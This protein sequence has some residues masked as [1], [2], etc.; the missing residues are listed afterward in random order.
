[1]NQIAAGGVGAD[2]AWLLA[3][4]DDARNGHRP[5]EKPVGRWLGDFLTEATPTGLWP[6]ELDLLLKCAKGAPCKPAISAAPPPDSPDALRRAVA[7]NVV[8]GEFLRFLILGG[9]ALAPVHEIGVELY[10]ALIVTDAH[11]NRVLDLRAGQCVG[12]V[13]LFNC[14]L[15]GALWI[16]DA[17]M[18]TLVL[19]G[20]R[21]AGLSGN[22]ATLTGSAFLDKQ[23]LCDGDVKLF[24]TQLGGGLILDDSRIVG[25]LNGS[26][27][28]LGG[29]LTCERGWFGGAFSLANADIKAGFEGAGGVFDGGLWGQ[30]AQIAGNVTLTDVTVRQTLTLS[31]ARVGGLLDL[32]GAS[33]G[34]EEAGGAE[35]DIVLD[36]S[37]AQIAG[38]LT[39]QTVDPQ[40]PFKAAGTLNIASAEIG[41]SAS[42][43]GAKL[44]A[45]PQ[46][47]MAL[48]GRNLCVKG[49]L[50]FC[51]GF[52]ADGQIMLEGAN[53]SKT[54]DFSYGIFSGKS[55]IAIA[56]S[57]ISVDGDLSMQG[58]A[59]APFVARGDVHLSGA[60]CGGLDCSGGAFNKQKF[61]ALIC[62]LI[63]VKGCVL[64]RNNGLDKFSA[65]GGVS[66]HSASIYQHFDCGGGD[67]TNP[68]GTALN[69]QSARIGGNVFFNRAVG[70]GL[71][72]R[73]RREF[74][75]NA[76][77]MVSLRSAT[78]GQQLVCQFGTFDNAI[79]DNTNPA[80]C[81]D[82]LDLAGLAVTDT[83]FLGVEQRFAPGAEPDQ[84]PARVAGGINLTNASASKLVDDGLFTALPGADAPGMPEYVTN[85]G[86]Q[87]RCNLVLDQF[88]YQRLSGEQ[89]CDAAARGAWLMRQPPEHL[90]T[91]FLPQPFERLVAV[92]RA[93]GYDGDADEIGL[94][95]RRCQ[96]AADPWLPAG[97][98]QLRR[99]VHAGAKCLDF[100][101]LNGFIGYGY[102]IGKALGIL[103]LIA[104][105]FGC[106][107]AVFQGDIGPADDAK[108]ARAAP[109][110]NPWIYSADVMIPVVG[111]GEKA[112]FAPRT[113]LV[114]DVQMVETVLGWIGGVLLVSFVSGLVAKE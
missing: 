44:A 1:M 51:G 33:L 15:E 23:F 19:Q 83:I 97:K 28:R 113:D 93:A 47:D 25:P 8:R 7:K 102:R 68:G 41:G 69:A 57:R 4:R 108:A 91:G 48:D 2:L 99:L 20:S 71:T 10:N 112:A 98:T 58:V 56:A 54:L 70:E 84:R 75:F 36:L 77:G 95:K 101:F 5:R 67:F 13:A 78:I 37:C 88:T 40:K 87:L 64:L 109:H 60:T 82:A 43:F 114:F 76:H 110:F 73:Q 16:E 61:G 34:F 59:D 86:Q 72:L 38:D 30:G 65:T 17:R 14:Y 32:S 94:M 53:I 100:V 74:A 18:G 9:D 66:F 11:P 79:P 49:G 35:R 12:R 63:T 80:Y 39:L 85:N 29:R 24:S 106:F 22:R 26:S 42:L 46:S 111:L 105:F 107:Y 96:F 104:F 89:A 55:G 103:V 90:G 31:C 6:T 92:M 50:S 21:V 27:A 62:D 81:A 45:R 3:V 52:A